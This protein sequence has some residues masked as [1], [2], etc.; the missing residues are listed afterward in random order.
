MHSSKKNILL[1]S[2]ISSNQGHGRIYLKKIYENISQSLRVKIFVPND[3]I[4]IKENINFNDIVKSKIG[5]RETERKN[6][7][8]FG[9]FSQIFRGFKRLKLSFKIYNDLLKYVK[10][11]SF[12]SIHIL[13]SEYISLIYF[14][15]RFSKINNSK[16]FVTI[17]PSNFK[18][19]ELNFSSFYKSL[20]RPFLNYSFK[21][22]AGVVCHGNW[23]KEKLLDS[24]PSLNQK[25]IG[26]IYPSFKYVE[27]DKLSVRNKYRVPC[28]NKVVLFIG[29][30][31]KDKNIETA[32]KVISL[33]PAD[34][35]LIIAGSLSDYSR[36]DIDVL[37][38]NY[39][40]RDK[41]RLDFRFLEQKEF[42]NYFCLSDV[43]L[44][45]HNKS[46]KSGSGPVSDARSF[47]LPVVVSPYGQVADYVKQTKVGLVSESFNA[48][49][50]VNAII[51][52]LNSQE[53]IG[54][55]IIEASY[56]YSWEEF[57]KKHI[58]FYKI[59]E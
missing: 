8:N 38:D 48:L 52:V 11:N 15:L 17:H 35:T 19:K 54:S 51:E 3:F 23:I 13:D 4:E 14:I 22:V 5:F 12:K 9:I 58:E 10:V 42:Q 49:D 46:F 30:I 45:C 24:F 43:L 20:I 32:L 18:F 36:E 55:K 21:Y 57:S 27:F 28:E 7:K 39:S 47:G 56:F 41:V 59:D 37:I 25:I 26:L 40:V 53:E 44:S 31:R 34:F 6:F 16:L 1:V 29:M 2:F 50:F 33:L